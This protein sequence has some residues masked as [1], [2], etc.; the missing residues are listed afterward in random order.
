MGLHGELR[1]PSCLVYE[2]LWAGWSQ[3]TCCYPAHQTCLLTKILRSLHGTGVCPL[4]SNNKPSRA[5]TFDTGVCKCLTSSY[6]LQTVICRAR[7]G[8]RP[9]T[10]VTQI[11]V[12][13]RVRP[14]PTSVVT[15]QSDGAGVRVDGG[16][17]SSQGVFLFDKVFGPGS[18]QQE[19][20]GQ[21]AELV[22]SA[23]DGYQ[24]PTKPCF[25]NGCLFQVLHLSEACFMN[26]TSTAA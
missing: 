8:F 26:A 16:E 5:G 6:V 12:F 15:C 10:C 20:F 22:Q 24:V 4:L 17:P 14:S 19:V 23:L 2:P 13:C 11:R 3:T 18:S 9:R 21:V 25:S 7:P 1:P